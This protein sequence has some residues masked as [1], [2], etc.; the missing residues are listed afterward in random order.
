MGSAR[1][2]VVTGASSGIGQ[3]TARAL[4]A[5][6]FQV[7]VGARRLERLRKLADEIGGTAHVLDV[8]D[9]GS[10]SRFAEQVGD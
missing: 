2:A 4:A 8:T 10:V 5:D 7:A 3:A 6:G 1:R 9:E